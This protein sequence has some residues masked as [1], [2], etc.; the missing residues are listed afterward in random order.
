M[1]KLEFIKKV[2]EFLTSIN[3]DL[4]YRNNPIQSNSKILSTIYTVYEN[5][6]QKRH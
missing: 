3:N 6:R 5:A 2:K 1:G 4:E